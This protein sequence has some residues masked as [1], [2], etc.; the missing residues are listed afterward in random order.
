MLRINMIGPGRGSTAVSRRC[1]QASASSQS[2]HYAVLR[3][4][5]LGVGTEPAVVRAAG[6]VSDTLDRT[7]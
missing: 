2:A 1:I 7:M 3:H 6:A 4:A 5:W